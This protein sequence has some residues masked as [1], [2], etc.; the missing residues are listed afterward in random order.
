MLTQLLPHPEPGPHTADAGY[1]GDCGHLSEQVTGGAESMQDT[2]GG[3]LSW[4]VAKGQRWLWIN[5]TQPGKAQ[6]SVQMALQSNGFTSIFPF[7]FQN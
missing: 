7:L 6:K 3:R 5:E 1:T 2:W 4:G